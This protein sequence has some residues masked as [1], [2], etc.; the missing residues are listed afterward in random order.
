MPEVE[1]GQADHLSAAC[2]GAKTKASAAE[3][4]DDLNHY[5]GSHRL[6]L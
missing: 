6:F 3:S 2:S 5:G 1:E 4:D